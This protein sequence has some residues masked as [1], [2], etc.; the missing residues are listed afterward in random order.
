MEEI[1]AS[2]RTNSGERVTPEKAKRCSAVLACMRGI[3]EDLSALP[4][5]L[6]KRGKD[7][8]DRAIDHEVYPLLS[9]APNPIMTS[10]ELRE[11]II[12][13][14][15]LHGNFYVLRNDARDG[16]IDNLW[17]L[18]A[19]LVTRHG[20]ELLWYYSDA[21][22]GISGTFTADAVWRGSIMSSNGIDGIA[23]T[24]LAREAVG[25]LMAAE[26]QG[27]R[28][29]ANGVQSDLVLQTDA[30]EVD[31][32]TREELKK[33]FTRKYAGADNSWIP[34]LLTGGLDAKRIGLT[35][36][37]SQ[38]IEARKFQIGDIARVFRY[39]EVLLGTGTTGKSST[40]ASAEQFFMSYVKHTLT[41]WAVRIE[42]TIE[43]DL[44]LPRERGAYFVRHDFDQL[45][46]GDTQARYEAYQLAINFG[47]M[48][49]AEFR[50]KENLPFVPG[51]DYYL[52]PLNTEAAAGKD[53]NK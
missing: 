51:L 45:L 25:L 22:T 47:G 21:V 2:I 23:L 28:L 48:S 52:R 12:F 30:D 13:D 29:F 38:Y 1:F 19:G 27:A 9:S 24:L 10:L 18:Q 6:Y 31:D 20:L 17:P 16:T 46:R 5:V 39:P 50:R 33:A 40:Y 37:E 42:Q 32:D 35:A 26:K 7:G 43:R 49:P 11:H 36:Q 8:D 15:M 53:A 34:L 14:L 41:P 44:L 4:L 3:S